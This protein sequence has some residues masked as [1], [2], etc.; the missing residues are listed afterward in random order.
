MTVVPP[1]VTEIV[2]EPAFGGTRITN[3]VGVA[4]TTVA[5]IPFMKTLLRDELGLKP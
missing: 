5:A 1:T 3:V 4:D 2:P